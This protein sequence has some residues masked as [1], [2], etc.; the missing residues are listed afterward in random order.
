MLDDQP[1]VS[2]LVLNHDGKRFLDDLYASLKSS[3]YPNFQVM[4][5]D[6]AST[7]D[8]VAYTQTHYPWVNV[9]ETGCNGGFSYAYNEAFKRAKGKYYLV[10]NNDVTVD[11]GWIEPLVAAMEADT[12]LGAVQPKLVSMLD[13]SDFEYAGASGGFLDVYGFPFLRGRLF[14]TLE[15][16]EG[17]YDD[18]VRIFWTTGAAMLV[19]AEALKWTGGLDEDFV[20]HME[21][22]D[23]CW[24]MNL[25]GYRLK[26]IPQ[27]VV[28]HYGGATIKPD[29]YQK[30]YWNHRNSVFMLLKNL[31]GKN[32]IKRLFGRWLLDLMAISF[33][34]A[35]WDWNRARA[36]IAGHNWLVLRAG[37]IKRQRTAVQ[38]LRK[39][40]DE[41][42]DHLF[43]QGSVALSYFLKGKRSY[44]QVM[45]DEG[46]DSSPHQ[47]LQETDREKASPS[48]KL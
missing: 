25:V 45:Q 30:I 34:V 20:H 24:R 16:D 29:S 27:S 14:N 10:L 21:E 42:L 43:Y 12:G 41:E 13:P 17:Q 31:S 4:L 26:A 6:N 15:K 11:P 33:A 9:F 23:L 1:L 44:Q 36:I 3:T 8:S 18:D 48:Q 19:R 7:D 32:L 38:A 40:E 35:K 46:T 5:I 39:V 2:I 47:S 22:I 28:Y 37:Y